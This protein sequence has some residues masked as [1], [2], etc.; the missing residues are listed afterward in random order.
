VRYVGVALRFSTSL[1]FAAGII[2]VDVKIVSVEVKTVV[3]AAAAEDVTII[4][5]VAN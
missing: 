3:V 5:D 1:F 4:V 2:V